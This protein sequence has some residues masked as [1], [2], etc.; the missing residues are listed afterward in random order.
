M[1]C[2]QLSVRF[3][4]NRSF[5]VEVT[6]FK[7][8][9]WK[10]GV[11][12]LQCRIMPDDCSFQVKSSGLEIKLRKKRLADNWWSLFKQRAIGEKDTDEEDAENDRKDAEALQKAQADAAIKS[13]E[14]KK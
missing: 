10:F 11:P 7:G 12:K 8:Q 1:G 6:K 2:E 5:F 4:T 9:D 14:E 3:P 13:F